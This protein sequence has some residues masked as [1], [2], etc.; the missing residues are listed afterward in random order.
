MNDRFLTCN[1]NGWCTV[2][3]GDFSS[4]ASY[5]T[6][7]PFD[8]IDAAIHAIESHMPFCVRFDAEGWDFYVMSDVCNTYVVVEKE[9]TIF[10]KCGSVVDKDDIALQIYKDISEDFDE[11]VSFFYEYVDDPYEESENESNASL[12]DKLRCKLNLLKRCL[13]DNEIT[14]GGE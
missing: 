8:C 3:L 1:E 14:W 12:E 2:T 13:D 4:R 11:W 10:Y 5:L 9:D 7:V 6:D